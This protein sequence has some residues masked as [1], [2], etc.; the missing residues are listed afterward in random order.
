MWYIH[1][2]GPYHYN[3]VIMSVMA[4]QITGVSVAYS[5]VGSGADQRKHATW[6]QAPRHRWPVNSPHKGPVTRKLF[7]YDNV[8][9][10]RMLLRQLRYIQNTSINIET[11]KKLCPAFDVKMVPGDRQPPFGDM[12]AKWRLGS[13]SCKCM[14]P[15][16]KGTSH[17]Y[18]HNCPNGDWHLALCLYQ[19]NHGF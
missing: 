9:L 4:S 13:Q 19:V 10:W 11:H 7:L 6:K 1:C 14:L 3:D 15:A 8:I 12:L 2:S 17:A 16:V 18:I 5:T